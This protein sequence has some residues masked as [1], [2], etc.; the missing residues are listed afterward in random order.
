MK[1]RGNLITGDCLLITNCELEYERLGLID[2][3]GKDVEVYMNKQHSEDGELKTSMYVHDSGSVLIE[4]ITGFYNAGM[5]YVKI[6][7]TR[8]SFD[9]R[10]S[11]VELDDL[12]CEF[13]APV[14]ETQNP[15]S[16]V[17]IG[18]EA[19][20]AGDEIRAEARRKN[21]E[22]DAI[23]SPRYIFITDIDKSGFISTLLKNQDIT[24]HMFRKPKPETLKGFHHTGPLRIIINQ[25]ISNVEEMRE[26]AESICTGKDQHVE[27]V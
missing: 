5:G 17:I 20:I 11:S 15:V 13:N 27:V 10:G 16:D 25:S 26:V 19:Q 6:E 9:F 24:R 4:Q 14:I 23:V 8:S 3:V 22:Q 1:L 2:P 7:T 12:I 18:L 21:R